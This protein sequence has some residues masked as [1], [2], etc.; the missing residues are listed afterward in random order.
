MCVC[1]VVFIKQ[2]THR[3]IYKHWGSVLYVY[4]IFTVYVFMIYVYIWFLVL[5]SM[6]INYSVQFFFNFFNFVNI[7]L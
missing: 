6:F 5:L 2:R 1:G 3:A 4:I 7:I